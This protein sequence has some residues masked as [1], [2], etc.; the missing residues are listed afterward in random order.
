MPV[1][2]AC[3]V[4]GHG[5]TEAVPVLIRRIAECLD[6]ALT[7]HIPHPVRIP[8]SRLLKQAELERAV[9]LAARSIGGHGAILVMMDSDDDC[10]ALLGPRLAG[11][12]QSRRRDIPVAVVLAKREYEAWLLSAAHSLRGH[13]GLPRDLEPPP[14]PESLR[15]AKER[16]SR[17]MPNGVYS[18]TLDQAALTAVFDLEE[19]RRAESFDKC[20]RE[21]FRLL[22]QARSAQPD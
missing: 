19:A 11:W 14:D 1:R 7:V 22:D 9:E 15:G 2:V 20:Y 18:E 21:V 12:A 8:R 16:L 5:E 6:P 13:R 17:S 3:V 10:P 4:E